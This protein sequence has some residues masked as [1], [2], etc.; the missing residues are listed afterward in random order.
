MFTRTPVGNG[1]Y[2]QRRSASSIRPH[3]A[4]NRSFRSGMSFSALAAV[5]NCPRFGPKRADGVDVCNDLVVIMYCLRIVSR[6]HNLGRGQ[7]C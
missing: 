4:F 7:L 5:E 1:T 3:A 2:R 6:K